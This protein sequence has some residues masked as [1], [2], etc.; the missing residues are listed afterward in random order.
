MA[1]PERMIL[2]ETLVHGGAAGI[3]V[4]A[5]IFRRQDRDE[6]GVHYTN[7]ELRWRKKGHTFRLEQWSYGLRDWIEVPLILFPGDEVEPS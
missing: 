4:S 1:K 5:P 2:G 3:P 6:K 7:N